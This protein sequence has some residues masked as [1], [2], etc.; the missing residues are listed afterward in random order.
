MSQR[1]VI[2]SRGAAVAEHQRRLREA[3]LL[4]LDHPALPTLLQELHQLPLAVRRVAGLS[5]GRDPERL[6]HEVAHEVEDVDDR[7]RGQVEPA[8]QRR[9]HERHRHR[10]RDRGALWSQLAEHDVQHGDDR[11]RDRRRQAEAEQACAVAEHR[12][13]QLVEGRLAYGAEAQGGERDAELAGGQVR[14]DVLDGV[15]R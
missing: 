7:L 12:L 8:H 4:A 1:G 6:Q 14:V 15:L 3:L 11:E 13:E 9:E 2:T 10:P 5:G